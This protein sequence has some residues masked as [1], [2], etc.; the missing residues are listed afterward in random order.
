MWLD[1]TFSSVCVLTCKQWCF[2][3]GRQADLHHCGGQLWEG[4]CRLLP[5]LEVLLKLTLIE[6]E[7][8]TASS[9][10]SFLAR[11]AYRLQCNL[12]RQQLGLCFRLQ[13]PHS[14]GC[15]CFITRPADWICPCSDSLN[16][17]QS[18][19]VLPCRHKSGQPHL[20]KMYPHV[21]LAKT[22]QY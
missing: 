11:L 20:T 6:L 17:F 8:Y 12:F 19:H 4:N 7:I 18:G 15:L 21:F 13:A 10:W 16:D 3:K 9:N 14:T 1:G 5:R 22:P 2:D